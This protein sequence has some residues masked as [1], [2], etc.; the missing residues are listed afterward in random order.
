MK[1]TF[2]ILTLFVGVL[3][4]A[5]TSIDVNLNHTYNGNA[6]ELDKVIETPD[7]D[8]KITRFQYYLSNFSLVHDNASETI[9]DDSYLLVDASNNNYTLNDVTGVTNIERVKFHYGI[10]ET[11]NHA[12]PAL[13]PANHP[14]NY[15][16]PSMHW[17][18]AGGYMF[19]V[20]EGVV[21]TDKNGTFE[22]G[23]DFMPVA[24]KYYTLVDL[25]TIDAINSNKLLLNIDVRIDKWL[26]G[27]DLATVGINHGQSSTLGSFADVV[28]R[29]VFSTSA[30][31]SSNKQITVN[32]ELIS[33]LDNGASAKILVKKP[34]NSHELILS[35]VSGKHI[36]TMKLNR[37][38]INLS[39]FIETSG[40]YILLLQNDKKEVIQ[41]KKISFNN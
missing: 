34:S 26:E 37:A 29:Q 33:V 22:T 39:D 5:Q 18:W 40:I 1:K 9:I 3:A 11:T 41:T 20:V 17:G 36:S 14:L 24:D 30:V 6:F 25:P 12:D 35:D 10:D 38:L 2:L 15:Q 7:Y 4:N 19:A 13:Q 32:N 27:F 23:F 21:D 28:T 8:F 16:S 31:L